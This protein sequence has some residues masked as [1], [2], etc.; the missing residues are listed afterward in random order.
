[1]IP[2][3][4]EHMKTGT[5]ALRVGSFGERLQ[6][7]REMRG[8]TLE[9][10]AEA[11]KIGTR[12][13]TALEQEDFGKLP[14]GIFNKG[15]VRAYARFLGIDEEEAVADYLIATGESAANSK[16]PEP[17][18]VAQQRAAA[19]A[20]QDSPQRASLRPGFVIVLV[21]VALLGG[22]GW[23]YARYQARRAAAREAA[24][25]RASITTVQTPAPAPI[26]AAAP[27][28]QAVAPPAATLLPPAQPEVA[29]KP[30]SAVVP[31]AQAA[32]AEGFVLQIRALQP[33]WIEVRADG[34]VVS[35]ETLQPGTE[36]S[37]TAKREVI[38]KTGNAAGIEMSHNGKPIPAMGASSQPRTVTFTPEGLQR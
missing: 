30:A 35:S 13:L 32:A 4:S 17:E 15:F 27:L 18:V 34:K 8:V 22:G 38:L 19:K 24:A 23:F 28:P 10:I 3:T 26:A 33:S 31:L 5:G 9:E 25:A 20:E 7:E 2:L 21:L 1:M 11:T 37:V 6:R 14:G 36:R 29:K 16:Q 12:L